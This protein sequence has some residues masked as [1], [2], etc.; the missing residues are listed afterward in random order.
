MKNTVASESR[1]P[2]NGYVCSA[3][4]PKEVQRLKLA[5]TMGCEQAGGRGKRR[6]VVG[7][8][9]I[10]ISG[11]HYAVKGRPLDFS[12]IPLDKMRFVAPR[13][14]LLMITSCSALRQNAIQAFRRKFPNAYIFGWLSSSPDD[15]NKLMQRF[16]RTVTHDVDLGNADSMDRLIRTWRTFVEAELSTAQGM[17]PWGLGYATPQGEVTYY[18]RRR[19]GEWKWV[20]REHARVFGIRPEGGSAAGD[21]AHQ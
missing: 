3:F 20:T 5:E 1:S 19:G 7:S 17:R 4:G 6:R 16:L 21:W 18:I 12:A 10:M 2:L 13:V 15:Q 11:H 14:R 8:D 9:I